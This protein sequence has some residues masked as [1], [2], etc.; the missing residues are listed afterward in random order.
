MFTAWLSMIVKELPLFLP[1]I[2]G[3]RRLDLRPASLPGNGRL[4][5]GAIVIRDG[6]MYRSA[7]IG[8]PKTPNR[9]DAPTSA[10]FQR[11]FRLRETFRHFIR[12]KTRG[13]A[14]VFR[15][16]RTETV[17]CLETA[18]LVAERAGEVSLF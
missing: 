18:D 17:S 16:C 12:A 14:R 3:L 11:H 9:D 4:A 13:V 5:G 6:D 1:I 8:T 10:E 7:P 15:P 2:C